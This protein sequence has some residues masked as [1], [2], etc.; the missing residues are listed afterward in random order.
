MSVKKPYANT[1]SVPVKTIAD[2][3]PM[4]KVT[5]GAKARTTPAFA[6]P[7]PGRTPALG[8]PVRITKA[9]P[10]TSGHRLGKR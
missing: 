3:N 8:V 1:P 10:A 4:G 6:P 5:I 9:A 2:T 7:K